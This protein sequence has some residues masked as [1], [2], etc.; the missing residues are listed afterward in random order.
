MD[1]IKFDQIYLPWYKESPLGN[2]FI[3]VHPKDLP[4]CWGIKYTF[5]GM[6]YIFMPL[7]ESWNPV[8]FH[9]EEDILLLQEYKEYKEEDNQGVNA[10]L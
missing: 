3:T 9:R 8:D 2:H 7:R 10:V 1:G 6:I 5:L 4:E